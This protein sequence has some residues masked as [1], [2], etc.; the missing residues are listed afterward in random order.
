VLILS[1]LLEAG[2]TSVA[3]PASLATP[4]ISPVPTFTPLL[5]PSP[6][7]TDTPIPTETPLPTDTP[8]PTE[9]PS[10]TATAV[11]PAVIQGATDYVT[12]TGSHII[13]GEIL[14]TSP[15]R[16]RF[17][18]VVA[19]YYDA[20]E[21][22]IATGS[23]FAELS[24]VEAGSR[25]PFR[26]VTSAL[27]PSFHRY[28]LRMNHSVTDQASLDLEILSHGA[29]LDDAGAHHIVGE[30]RNPLGFPITSARVVATYYNS[31]NQP[32]RVE[33]TLNDAATLETGQTASFELVLSDP[34]GDLSHY[35]LQTEAVQQ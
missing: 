26:L 24:I 33:T 29:F 2:V 15:G 11:P 13:V 4:S 25:A 31:A 19:T 1:A 9:T 27:P 5:Y 34:P 20:D 10:P 16:L 28:A 18:E 35:K 6:L 22:M 23:T 17:V 3:L 14:N 7:P 30:L 8:V 32:I 21:R 12:G